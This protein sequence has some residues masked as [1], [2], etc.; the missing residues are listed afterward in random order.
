MRFFLWFIFLFA[1]KNE[2][3]K[4]HPVP[5]VPPEAGCP[6]FMPIWGT[7][8]CCRE[9]ANS[10]RSNSANSFFGNLSGA[11]RRANGILTA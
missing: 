9:F 6:E 7:P 10:L 8:R 11:R 3:K 5:L 4:G 2:P 1:Q